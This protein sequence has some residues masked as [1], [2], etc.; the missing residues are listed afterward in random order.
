MKSSD[1]KETKAVIKPYQLHKQCEWKTDHYVMSVVLNKNEI[2]IAYATGRLEKRKLKDGSIIKSSPVDLGLACKLH[3]LGQ[4]IVAQGTS[5]VKLINAKTLT[6]EST[7]EKHQFDCAELQPGRYVALEV[8][9]PQAELYDVSNPKEPKLLSVF[10]LPQEHQIQCVAAIPAEGKEEPL[11]VMGCK[12]GFIQYCKMTELD[13]PEKHTRITVDSNSEMSVWSIAVMCDKQLAISRSANRDMPYAPIGQPPQKPT[14]I[15]WINLN[16]GQV[17]PI[18]QVPDDVEV[19][20]ILNGASFAMH[21]PETQH[22]FNR[23]SLWDLV[24]EQLTEICFDEGIRRC[25]FY[26]DQLVTVDEK[27]VKVNQMQLS[28]EMV[29]FLRAQLNMPP[30]LV[31]IVASYLSMFPQPKQHK[32]EEKDF[33]PPKPPL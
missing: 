2:F 25:A 8:L 31:D 3:R 28:L 9:S 26:K 14:F 24:A 15:D 11:I 13:S 16:T 12:G 18:S 33:L 6:E 7:L 30:V 22:R 10:S 29:N 17:K 21:P 1:E 27:Q 4:T 20:P 5:A 19:T 32:G 23:M